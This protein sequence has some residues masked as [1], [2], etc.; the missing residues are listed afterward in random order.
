MEAAAPPQWTGLPL[1]GPAPD[2]FADRTPLPPLLSGLSL[3]EKEKLDKEKRAKAARDRRK[4]QAEQLAAI[5]EILKTP[6]R[7]IKR[8]AEEKAKLD[9]Q[10][11]A[12]FSMDR[13]S[14]MT[15]APTGVGELVLAGGSNEMEFVAAAHS[16]AEALGS[17]G[18]D[19]GTGEA[20][21]AENDRRS[22]APEGKGS[23]DSEDSGSFHVR[24]GDGV[25]DKRAHDYSLLLDKL[26]ERY[27]VKVEVP[28]TSEVFGNEFFSCTSC[29][30]QQSRTQSVQRCARCGTQNDKYNG[31]LHVCRLCGTECDGLVAAKQHM[32]RVHGGENRPEHDGRYGDLTRRR[33]HPITG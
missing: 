23:D 33:K 29:G 6:I 19:I 1:D 16:R 7:E 24:L 8:L 12:L 11:R 26:A 30:V 15:D 3:E 4:H 22:I 28:W 21:W 18:L 5:K 9:K 13:G 31:Y 17:P 2:P 10:E 25:Q 27:F 14:W 20:F 32:H